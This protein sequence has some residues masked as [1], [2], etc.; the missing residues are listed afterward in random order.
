MTGIPSPSDVPATHRVDVDDS[1]RAR[2]LWLRTADVCAGVVP[3]LG[4]RVL[5]L[6][7][8]AGEHIFRNPE[9]LD[10]A[11]HPAVEIAEV[12]EEP[13]GALGRWL[14]SGGDKTWPAPQGWSGPSEWPGP[15]DTVLDGGPYIA[16]WTV[17]HARASIEM[18]SPDDPRTGLRIR[19]RAE[20]TEGTSGYRLT[21]TFTNTSD[22][23]IRW[24]IWQVVQY[25]GARPAPEEATDV[26]L[27]VWVSTGP[28]PGVSV[29][30]LIVG[31]GQ[32]TVDHSRADVLWVPPQ[33]VVGKVGFPTA[34]GW[35]AHAEVSRVTALQFAPQPAA[36]YPDRGSRVEVRTTRYR[37]CR[38]FRRRTRARC[39][40]RCLP[41]R[42][43]GRRL[44]SVPAARDW[45]DRA[46]S[47]GP[48][49]LALL[50]P[51]GVLLG[52]IPLG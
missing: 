11:I 1:G 13:D 25:P 37:R 20:V 39:P 7:T 41:A 40:S 33:D 34:N 47:I 15:P 6:A 36:T 26:G 43:V 19:R 17:D 31:T 48:V 32:V 51:T 10:N 50:D 22:R 30:N 12:S 3:A 46:F 23:E 8:K 18:R 16:S 44:R 14:N 35:V 38:L 28:G 21:S 45:K 2:V 5:S 29:E 27:G 24:A 9:L 52:E 49:T 42:A 4:G